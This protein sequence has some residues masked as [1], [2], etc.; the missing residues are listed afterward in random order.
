MQR[1]N[2]ALAQVDF[3]QLARILSKNYLLEEIPFFLALAEDQGFTHNVYPAKSAPK[4]LDLAF[5]LLNKKTLEWTPIAFNEINQQKLAARAEKL[6]LRKK[7]EDEL[8]KQL[9]EKRQLELE[10]QANVKQVQQLNSQAA[11]RKRFHQEFKQADRLPM[12]SEQKEVAEVKTPE[13]KNPHDIT[14]DEKEEKAVYTVSNAMIGNFLLAAMTASRMKRPQQRPQQRPLSAPPT[15]SGNLAA[16]MTFDIS[17][18]R[19]NPYFGQFIKG[20]GGVI[21][22]GLQ[23]MDRKRAA[24]IKV[25]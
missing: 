21:D 3:S 20:L 1:L 17:S 13:E 15:E 25:K 8:T 18:I 10:K 19:N 23:L 14:G 4:G 11:L 2:P 16:G 6:A 9:D 7:I 24:C 5:K 22:G 12:L